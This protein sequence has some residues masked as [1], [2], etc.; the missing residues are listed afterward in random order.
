MV[1]DP[2]LKHEIF[3]TWITPFAAKHQ[4][5]LWSLTVTLTNEHHFILQQIYPCYFLVLLNWMR[6]LKTSVINLKICLFG[7]VTSWL[8]GP[9]GTG[10]T[11]FRDPL[12]IYEW[13][14]HFFQRILFY[15]NVALIILNYEYCNFLT[16]TLYHPL[17]NFLSYP[18]GGD[19]NKQF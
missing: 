4:R 1:T 14:L 5:C 3:R 2:R 13:T 15:A 6:I 16:T 9:W 19:G 10:T 12:T 11:L 8:E 7:G 17:C 18:Y